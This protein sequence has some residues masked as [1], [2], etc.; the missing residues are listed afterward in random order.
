ML[1]RS[2]RRPAKNSHKKSVPMKKLSF[3][4]HED[5]DAGI[6]YYRDIYEKREHKGKYLWPI[7]ASVSIRSI[8]YAYIGTH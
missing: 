6:A 8:V 4:W 1:L 7:I 5:N 3:Q 2:S